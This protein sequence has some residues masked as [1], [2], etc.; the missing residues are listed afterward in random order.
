MQP[1]FCIS[2]RFTGVADATGPQTTLEVHSPGIKGEY[3]G[4]CGDSLLVFPLEFGPVVCKEG[5]SV[6]LVLELRR[7]MPGRSRASQGPSWWWQQEPSKKPPKGQLQRRQLDQ[8]E[9]PHLESV[10]IFV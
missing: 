9:F 3:T 8:W 10:C 5:G 2:N 6:H 7:E 4:G 1:G